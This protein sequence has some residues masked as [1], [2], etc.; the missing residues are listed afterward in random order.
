MG[1][2][3]TTGGSLIWNG[4]LASP[5]HGG[6]AFDAAARALAA[7]ETGTLR[8]APGVDPGRLDVRIDGRSVPLAATDALELPVGYHHIQVVAGGPRGRVVRTFEVELDTENPIVVA[9]PHGLSELRLAPYVGS[10]AMADFIRAAGFTGR[11]WVITDT[12]VWTLDQD[13]TRVPDPVALDPQTLRDRAT[14]RRA[15]GI[16]TLLSGA[17]VTGMGAWGRATSVTAKPWEE[18]AEQVEYRQTQARVWGAVALTG[19]G[20]MTAG[21]TLLVLTPR[22]R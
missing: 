11:T 2:D 19:L 13:W 8:I 15:V 17:I 1:S 4:R 20:G 14:R 22:P 10:P 21:T 12:D 3:P 5:A 7:A 6:E 18:R 16:S 9:D